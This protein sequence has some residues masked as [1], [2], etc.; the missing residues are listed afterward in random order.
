MLVVV[1]LVQIARA[2]TT[3]ESMKGHLSNHDA[4][5]AITSFVMTGSV[6]PNGEGG[7]TGGPD[8]AAS[9]PRRESFFQQWKRILGI[10]TFLTLAVKWTGGNRTGAN[11][12]QR[13]YNRNPF[14]RGT[15]MNCRDFWCDGLPILGKRNNGEAA[16]GGER[17][18]YTSMYEPPRMAMTRG[19][20]GVYEVVD[21][22]DDV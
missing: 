9:R 1:Q 8:P 13:N 3:Y 2:Q 18:H 11:R 7:D 17:V 20:G 5:D 6:G 14:N 21:A 19:D 12:I 15:I 10:D 16:L 4:G 22:D